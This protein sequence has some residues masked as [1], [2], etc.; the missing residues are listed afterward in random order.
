MPFQD[1]KNCTDQSLETADGRRF[2]NRDR[3]AQLMGWVY[4]HADADAKRLGDRPRSAKK[5]V[6]WR[7]GSLLKKT[8][9][10]RLPKGFSPGRKTPGVE[11]ADLGVAGKDLA[12]F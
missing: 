4:F 5:G 10:K 9:Q 3:R 6:S 11:G 1:G 12:D 2:S 8:P 7:S